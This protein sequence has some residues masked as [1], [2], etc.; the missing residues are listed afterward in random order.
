MLMPQKGFIFL[1]AFVVIGFV[2]IK[3]VQNYAH[4]MKT[5]SE[6]EKQA[7]QSAERDCDKAQ[8]DTE[9]YSDCVIQRFHEYRGQCELPR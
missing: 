5:P 9:A 2:A 4:R 3:A 1:F 6:C 8:Q 7:M